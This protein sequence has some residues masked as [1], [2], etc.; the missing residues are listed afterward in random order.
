MFSV[1]RRTERRTKFSE[2]QTLTIVKDDKAGRKGAD[3]RRANGIS[4]QT[5]YRWRPK[6]G[7]MELNEMQRLK[8]A[9][10]TGYAPG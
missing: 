10:R 2:E 9:P 4:E 5:Y 3:L 1:Q 8:A 7:G 6:Y